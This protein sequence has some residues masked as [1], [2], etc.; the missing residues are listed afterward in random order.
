MA[1][2]KNENLS[3]EASVVDETVAE[4]KKVLFAD[5]CRAKK[6]SI[7]NGFV[8]FLYVFIT[9]IAIWFVDVVDSIKRNPIKIGAYLIAIP[10]IFIGFFMNV[11]IETIYKTQTEWAPIFVFALVLAGMINIFEAF[12]IISKKNFGSIL[13]ASIL[14]GLIVVAGIVYIYEI[15]DGVKSSSQLEFDS[16]VIRSFIV[17]TVS[18]ILSVVGCVIAWIFRDKNYK[19]DKF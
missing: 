15:S 3:T 19:R 18:M 8:R 10:G 17:I 6:E 11:E 1:E 9:A 13:I 14:T 5:R 7:N 16:I 2:I 4:E 12:S